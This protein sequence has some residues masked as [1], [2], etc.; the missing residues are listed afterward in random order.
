VSIISAVADGIAT[1]EIAR[2]EKKNAVTQAM[3]LAFAAALRNA[4]ST[5][6]VRAVLIKGQPNVFCAGNDLED[7]L[8]HSQPGR[9]APPFQFMQAM[10]DCGKP[11]VAA[12]EGPAVGIGATLLL[13]CDF[14]YLSDNA[15]LSMP[16]VRLGLVPEFGSSFVLPRLM[17]AAPANSKLLL[18]DPITAAEAVAC[19]IA[20]ASMPSA[21]VLA[22][23]TQI[24]QRL[25]ALPAGALHDS[26]QL[27][28]RADRGSLQAAIDAEAEIFIARLSSEEARHAMQE[29]KTP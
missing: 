23:A 24:A 3:Y 4:N 2:P 17:G 21:D 14:V 13:H 22:H 26:K 8:Q 29:R 11:I 9:D 25:A 19:G 1:I 27:L 16:F 7:F 15:T 12:V 18:G 20:N 10:L 28:R 6:D 5:V